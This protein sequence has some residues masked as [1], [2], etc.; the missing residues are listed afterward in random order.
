M[1]KEPLEQRP[2]MW[3]GERSEYTNM[4]ERLTEIIEYIS[5]PDVITAEIEYEEA[6]KAGT[7]TKEQEDEH[8]QLLDLKKEAEELRNSLE[9]DEKKVPVYEHDFVF[10]G[11]AFEKAGYVDKVNKQAVMFERPMYNVSVD[12]AKIQELPVNKYGEVLLTIRVKNNPEGKTT[13]QKTGLVSY[14]KPNCYVI[15]TPEKDAFKFDSKTICNI[16]I[17]KERLLDMPFRENH[18][19]ANIDFTV[20]PERKLVYNMTNTY[21]DSQGQEV[22]KNYAVPLEGSV[23]RQ[24]MKQIVANARSLADK[25]NVHS[26]NL[27]GMAWD[28]TSKDGNPYQSAVLKMD[29]MRYAPKDE[30]NNT[31]LSLIKNPK[32]QQ[33]SN[34]ADYFI[35]WSTLMVN[36]YS[37]SNCIKE[38]SID[39]NRLQHFVLPSKYT[40]KENDKEVEKT[41]D[42]ANIMIGTKSVS[43]SYKTYGIDKATVDRSIKEGSFEF[44]LGKVS[45]PVRQLQE[46]TKAKSTRKQA[47]KSAAAKKEPSKRQTAGKK[48]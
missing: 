48:M 41:E 2:Y 40:I 10:V 24:T 3:H 7:V 1:E 22:S 18:G 44:Y 17:N 14:S 13:D 33:G 15:A 16:R 23:S 20:T 8:R 11:S 32:K 31:K 28:R 35:V 34:Q 29:K 21:V 42:V 36:E 27:V 4:Q 38:L 39:T 19:F 25:D 6:A 43:P 46:E 30:R 45:E 12:R 26:V 47:N 9:L 37:A 5:D